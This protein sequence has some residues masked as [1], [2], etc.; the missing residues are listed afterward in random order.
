MALLSIGVIEFVLHT[1]VLFSARCSLS[2]Y[3]NNGTF[4]WQY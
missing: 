4:R 3:P 1:D 2:F